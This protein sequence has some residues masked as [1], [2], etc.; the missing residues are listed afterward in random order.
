VFTEPT[1]YCAV[2][3]SPYLISTIAVRRN[4]R[5]SRPSLDLTDGALGQGNDA[6]TGIRLLTFN[7]HTSGPNYAAKSKLPPCQTCSHRLKRS[8]IIESL[9]IELVPSLESF[10]IRFRSLARGSAAHK[11]NQYG[12]YK[13]CG[14]SPA[15]RCSSTCLRSLWHIHRTFAE[16]T[17]ICIGLGRAWS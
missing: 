16:L 3:F 17:A 8:I 9:D 6:V 13:R 1:Q 5:L 12:D 4:W 15:S 10:D 11:R 2:L 7:L 14:S